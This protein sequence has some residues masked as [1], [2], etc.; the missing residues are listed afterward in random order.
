[1][2]MSITNTFLLLAPAAA[3]PDRLVTIYAHW[4]DYALSQHYSEN[5]SIIVRTSGDP[6]LWVEPMDKAI[7]S[8]GI[9]TISRPATF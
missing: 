7:R 9:I 6:R 3:D 4:P 1:M 8:L 2:S 5:I